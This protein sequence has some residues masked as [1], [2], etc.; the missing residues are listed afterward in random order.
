MTILAQEKTCSNPECKEVYPYYGVA[1][2][3]CFYKIPGGQLGDSTINPVDT[4]PNN[5]L[6]EWDDSLTVS[7]NLKYGLCGVWVCP[8]CKEVGVKADYLKSATDINKMIEQEQ[9]LYLYA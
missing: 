7:Q 6:A 9:E 4:W 1:P 5:F 8:E 3:E 2:H